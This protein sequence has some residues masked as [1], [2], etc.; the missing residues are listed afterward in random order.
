MSVVHRGLRILAIVVLVHVA[1]VTAALLA[2]QTPWAHDYLRGLAERRASAVLN[3]EVGIGSLGGPL[4]TGASVRELTIRRANQPIVSIAGVTV[5]YDPFELIGGTFH[6]P[7]I[8]V[9]RPVV[10]ATNIASLF[11]KRDQSR[12]GSGTAFT[13]DELVIKD[14]RVVIGATP[15]QVAGFRVPDV[16]R[17]LQAQLRLHSGSDETSVDVKQL[18][19]VGA[20][21][22]ITLKQLSG[23]VSIDQGDLILKDI[24]VQLAESSFEFGGTIRD[25]RSLGESDEEDEQVRSGARPGVVGSAF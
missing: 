5:D 21:P 14:G 18:S 9:D 19:F 2:L 8:V 20:S 11:P 16:I 15:E 24:S 22:A 7:K 4:L 3:A 10:Q 23:S 13:I 17:D 25:F 12:Q 1:H 6:L